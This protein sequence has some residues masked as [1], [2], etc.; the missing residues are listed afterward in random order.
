[1]SS[2]ESCLE[3]NGEGEAG[4]ACLFGVAGKRG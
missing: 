1:M 3:D 2:E 4:M